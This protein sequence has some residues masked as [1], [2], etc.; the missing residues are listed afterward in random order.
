MALA[1]RGRRGRVRG[2][3][4]VA[5]PQPQLYRLAARPPVFS[6]VPSLFFLLLFLP[7]CSFASF[8]LVLRCLPACLPAPL[9]FL[10]TSLA[11]L[12]LPP[13]FLSFFRDTPG[14]FNFLFSILFINYYYYYCGRSEA[15]GAH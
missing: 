4:G 7:L 3:V 8:D 13:F 11:T 15:R 2:S 12:L 6:C 5:P 1:W 9:L 10:F 14:P